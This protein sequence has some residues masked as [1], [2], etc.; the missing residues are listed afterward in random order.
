V[1]VT[2]EGIGTKGPTLSTY[3]SIPG[4][5]LVMMPG[6][7]RLGVSRRIEDPSALKLRAAL[8]ELELP[9][10]MGFIAR[11]AALERTKASCRAT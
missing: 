10:G 5:F 7:G 2:K 4:R 6:M 3:L 11:T 9:D 8:G 1:Q